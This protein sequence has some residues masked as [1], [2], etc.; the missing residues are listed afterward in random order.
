[1]SGYYG[2]C[3]SSGKSR[4]SKSRSCQKGCKC[5]R[6]CDL[7]IKIKC[8]S[9]SEDECPPSPKCPK[10]VY[11]TATQPTVIPLTAGTAT[12][13]PFSTVVAVSRCKAKCNGMFAVSSGPFNTSTGV[14][15]VPQGGYYHIGT[16]VT[17]T[18][19]AL[20]TFTLTINV[21]GIPIATSN[22]IGGA[23][24][25]ETIP[26]SIDYPLMA[27]QTVQVVIT[28]D[29]AGASV[30]NVGTNFSLFMAYSC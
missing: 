2:S 16:N 3:S 24:I 23:G 4:R 26:L 11:L 14:F 1:M 25:T 30:S 28:A 13:I 18:A 10:P 15:T 27:G 12:P 17:V 8:K 6:C 5:D 9:S 20:T 21:N 7:K 29:V 19:T 22:F